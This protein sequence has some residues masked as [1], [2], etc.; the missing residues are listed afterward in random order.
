MRVPEE[1]KSSSVPSGQFEA[2]RDLRSNSEGAYEPAFFPRELRV[3]VLS[4]SP[5]VSSSE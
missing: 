4:T 5:T 3:V 2:S 1:K